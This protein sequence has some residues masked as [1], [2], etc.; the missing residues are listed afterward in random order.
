M[1]HEWW[2][3]KGGA[4]SSDGGVLDV[5]ATWACST[6]E[7]SALLLNAGGNPEALCHYSSAHVGLLAAVVTVQDDPFCAHRDHKIDFKRG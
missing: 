2:P 1:K 3:P 4:P 5:L 7:I 6:I